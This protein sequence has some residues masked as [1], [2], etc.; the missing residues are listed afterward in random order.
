MSAFAAVL[1]AASANLW[2]TAA[3]VFLVTTLVMAAAHAL[4]PR[5]PPLSL[6]AA[7]VR[8]GPITPDELAKHD[9]SDP[10]RPLY[11]AVQGTVYDVTTGRSF[12]GPGE[13]ERGE[14]RGWRLAHWRLPPPPPHPPT[15]TPTLFVA[16]GG[17]A[18]FAGK[19]VARALATMSL[20]AAVVGRGDV[21]DCDAK[22]RATL[23]DWVAKL[24]AKYPA[25]GTVVPPLELTLAQLAEHDG[26]DR[27]KPMLLAIS[28][29]VYDVSTGKDFYGPDG[30][31]PFAGRECARAFALVSTDVADCVA[32]VGG[33]APLEIDN[34]RE[35]KAK[36]D[37]KYPKV[38][39]VVA[40]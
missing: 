30:I 39:R 35:W 33:L 29:D 22:Q 13:A 8:C 10:F 28:G 37:F 9:G 20:D 4:A 5:P 14:G 18:C 32:D 40:G 21:D 24:A 19:E 34:L 1:D 16:G 7:G 38:G 31:Y 2:A 17:Y 15:P 25:V 26:R 23:A 11:L 27:G 12:Y 6:D 3:A 36:F